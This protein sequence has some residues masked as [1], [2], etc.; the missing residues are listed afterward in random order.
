[1]KQ[2]M[3]V[4]S[5]RSRTLRF[6]T[7][8]IRQL[9]FRA[10]RLGTDSSEL[11]G[12]SRAFSVAIQPPNLDLYWVRRRWTVCGATGAGRDQAWDIGALS[13]RIFKTLRLGT[14]LPFLRQ[15]PDPIKI[16]HA[17]RSPASCVLGDHGPEFLVESKRRCC[18][19]L[20][21]E[22]LREG[23]HPLAD[24]FQL[25]T[26]FARQVLLD[27]FRLNGLPLVDGAH[28][29]WGIDGWHWPT[30]NLHQVLFTSRLCPR[31]LDLLRHWLVDPQS[32]T[33]AFSRD[34]K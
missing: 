6:F 5:I 27:W 22:C 26:E 15:G 8:I 20:G 4:A 19:L 9:L 7:F 11:T 31:F 28:A 33:L 16:Q 17:L 34:R 21:L 14:T 1:M 13:N 25:V 23:A 24:R 29:L 18:Q 30:T 10:T 3:M 2:V 32:A 12:R